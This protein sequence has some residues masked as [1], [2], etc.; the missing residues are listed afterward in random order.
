[1][2]N[3]NIIMNDT[4]VKEKVS[5]DEALQ[6]LGKVT[7]AQLFAH[8]YKNGND[9]AIPETIL[10]KVWEDSPIVANKLE[11]YKT[12]V[13]FIQYCVSKHWECLNTDKEAAEKWRNDAMDAWGTI[14]TLV[15][16]EYFRYPTDWLYFIV[17]SMGFGKESK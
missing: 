1:M 4:Q 8:A 10:Q 17:S 9:K 12:N 13:Y 15:G 7:P 6:S 11:S 3:T 14:L 16:S 2:E 5:F